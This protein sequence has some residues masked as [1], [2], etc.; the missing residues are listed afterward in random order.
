[1]ERVLPSGLAVCGCCLVGLVEMVP[2]VLHVVFDICGIL[3][4]RVQLGQSPNLCQSCSDLR[5]V[6]YVFEGGERYG[7][8]GPLVNSGIHKFFGI[9]SPL[10]VLFVG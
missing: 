1:M 6:S 8:V 2:K 9:L 5:R 4:R 7:G 3:L 10:E